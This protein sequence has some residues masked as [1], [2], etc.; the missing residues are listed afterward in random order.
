[1]AMTDPPPLVLFSPRMKTARAHLISVL[2]GPLGL[3]V[4]SAF[5]L[6]AMIRAP[7]PATDV[8]PVFIAL[9]LLIY[10]GAGLSWAFGLSLLS[11]A[12]A[13]AGFFFS[14]APWARLLFALYGVLVWVLFA[15]LNA[16]DHRRDATWNRFQ[17]EWD[18]LELDL[19]R[20]R[21]DVENAR[22]VVEDSQTRINA[23][24]RLQL[25]TDD[26]VGPYHRD[27]LLQRALSGLGTMFPKSRVSLHLFPKPDVPDTNDELGLKML[28]WGQP[29]LL[30]DRASTTPTWEPGLMIGL[31][32]KGRESFLGW[33]SLEAKQA[34]LPFQIHDLRLASIA[35]D[36]VSLALGNT[37][38]YSQTEALA[39][40]DELTGVYTGATL[41]SG[42]WKNFAKPVTTDGRFRWCCWT[43]IILKNQR[44][45]RASHRRRS[46]ALVGSSGDG[47]GAG[48][49][50]CGPLRRGRICGDHALHPRR[51]RVSV[52]PTPGENRREHP[53]SVGSKK[54]QGHGFCWSGHADPR[55]AQR[56]GNDSSVRRGFVR[57]QKRR[58]QS[59]EGL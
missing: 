8:F 16:F 56:R 46:F 33:I 59:R 11:T 29:R 39:I 24:D 22:T 18:G 50:F 41:T 34:S 45:P 9:Q 15:I 58:A 51:R 5:T 1:M 40:S 14:P 26:L 48:N 12:V 53:L 2:L 38:R 35:S 3:P 7:I 43:S 4:F 31:P 28:Q 49:G 27:E 25:F 19:S 13:L 21:A 23:F 57:R 44:R 47:S 10:L 20:L 30:P 52:H 6:W 55:R 42:C 32:V 36:L 17:E 54:H 37:E